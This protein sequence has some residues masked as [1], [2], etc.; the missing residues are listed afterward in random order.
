MFKTL[1]LA[2][3]ESKN[4]LLELM[5]KSGRGVLVGDD[6]EAPRGFFL[7][8][9]PEGMGVLGI[10]S[11]GFGI[12]P[13]VILNETAGRVLVGHDC[14]ISSVLLSTLEIVFSERIPAVFYEFVQLKLDGSAVILHE[15][16]IL[17]LDTK[18]RTKWSVDTD[19]IAGFSRTQDGGIEL[20]EM[21]SRKLIKVSL[22]DGTH[23][24]QS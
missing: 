22:S 5:R 20:R 1:E 21:E 13:A 14:R 24:Q 2:S 10:I 19:I 6:A 7:I 4:T 23:V 8:Q 18:G 15:L 11:S 9:L 16:G 17:E 12:N 3:V